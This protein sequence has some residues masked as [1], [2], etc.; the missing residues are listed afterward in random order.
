MAVCQQGL[1]RNNINQSHPDWNALKTDHA[2]KCD[3]IRA[4]MSMP[5]HSPLHLKSNEIQISRDTS[6]YHQLASQQPGTY[7]EGMKR[8]KK[9][10]EVGNQF[11]S[12]HLFALI[13]SIHC[14]KRVDC[15]PFF[16]EAIEFLSMLWLICTFMY[17]IACFTIPK[18]ESTYWFILTYQ[19]PR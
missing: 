9:K 8:W 16:N 19:F 4:L 6:W 2:D 18:T 17:L 11:K 7:I 15:R 14:L 3:C 5:L 12:K 1:Q 10:V 13:M